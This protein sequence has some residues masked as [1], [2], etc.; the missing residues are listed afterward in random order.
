[1][2]YFA[3]DDNRMP[4]LFRI[5]CCFIVLLVVLVILGFLLA[6][7]VVFTQ[8]KES[9]TKSDAKLG[10]GITIKSVTLAA[11]EPS[12]ALAENLVQVRAKGLP[13]LENRWYSSSETS[14]LSLLSSVSARTLSSIPQSES[15]KPSKRS[16]FS[17][18]AANPSQTTHEKS[19]SRFLAGEVSAVSAAEKTKADNT[20]WKTAFNSS[21]FSV[22]LREEQPTVTTPSYSVSKMEIGYTSSYINLLNFDVML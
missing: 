13:A 14:S 20:G 18:N 4:K 17:A 12:A 10:E 22:T 9:D 2:S 5:L 11:S 21:P 19:S 16:L 1:M 15:S 3:A 6:K 7:F 8:S